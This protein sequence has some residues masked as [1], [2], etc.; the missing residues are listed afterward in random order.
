MA[1]KPVKVLADLQ[2]RKQ[3]LK[4]DASNNILF[5]VSGSLG[6]GVVTIEI[7]VTAS[8]GISARLYGTSSYALTASYAE[9]AG[10]GITSVYTSGSISGSGLQ[11]NPI[12]LKDPLVIGTITSSYIY[13]PQ[14]TGSLYGTASFA[15]SASYAAN[16]SVNTSSFA[17][18]GSN[19]FIGNQKITGSIFLDGQLV[20]TGHSILGAPA[21]QGS[22]SRIVLW[23]NFNNPSNYTYGLGIEANHMWFGVDVNSASW[24]FKWYAANAEIM[25]LNGVGDLSGLASVT[26]SSGFDGRLYGTSSYALTSS[27]AQ[28]SNISTSAIQNAYNRL[29]YQTIGNFDINGSAIIT[30]PSSSLGGLSFP[31]SSFD[32]INATIFINENGRWIND[33]LSVQVYTSST[34]V[35]IEISAPA[36][37]NTDQYKLLAVNENPSDYVII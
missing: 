19:L 8:A 20:N 12:F 3:I 18:T 4:L 5:K 7:P 16:A 15:T 36:L 23:D 6:D 25:K 33:L 28:S 10:G 30:L 2:T 27:Y 1:T 14:I 9:N 29:R 35:L 26:A 11:A 34:N 22:T 37:T 21:L 24:G 17:T 32:F 13:A 31:T